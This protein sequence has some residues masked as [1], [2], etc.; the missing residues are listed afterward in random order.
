[1]LSARR[2]GERRSGSAKTMSRAITAAPA[3][4]VR[5]TSS[6]RRVRGQGH[7][8]NSRRLAS[9][10]SRMATGRS[11]GASR[12][13][14]A[15][16][17]SKTRSLNTSSGAGSQMRSATR[18]GSRRRARARPHPTRRARRRGKP[19]DS[20]AALLRPPPMTSPGRDGAIRTARRRNAWPRTTERRSGRAGFMTRFAEG[21]P[22]FQE[23]L[24]WLPTSS[25]RGAR[26]NRASKDA[27]RSCVLRG[28][29][30][31]G[32]SA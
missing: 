2:G 5:R 28:P 30:S 13:A 19:P 12:G 15:W 7:W 25:S 6:A 16:K 26:R 1:M 8:P 21:W 27:P 24:P 32:T 22:L 9:S 3:S 23:S 18:T 17:A 4:L 11:A 14:S 20:R 29:P 10:M 31:A